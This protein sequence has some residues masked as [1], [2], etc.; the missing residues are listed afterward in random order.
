M[1]S[2]IKIFKT[3]EKNN[4]SLQ[5]KVEA[6]SGMKRCTSTPTDRMPI[7]LANRYVDFDACQHILSFVDKKTLLACRLVSRQF[8]NLVHLPFQTKS[9]SLMN[10]YIVGLYLKEIFSDKVSFSE[11]EAADIVLNIKKDLFDE[12]VD[13]IN[14]KNEQAQIKKAELCKFKKLNLSEIELCYDNFEKLN[15][16][17]DFFSSHVWKLK[18]GT[19]G[20]NLRTSSWSNLIELSVIRIPCSQVLELNNLKIKKLNITEIYD[21][22]VDWGNSVNHLEEIILGS[23]K[24]RSINSRN[25]SLQ[26]V[27]NKLKTLRID[28]SDIFVRLHDLPALENLTIGHCHALWLKN[29]PLKEVSTKWVNFLKLENLKNLIKIRIQNRECDC[30]V[31]LKGY[32]GHDITTFIAKERI[33]LE[34]D[35]VEQLHSFELPKQPN[36][37]TL[38]INKKETVP[39]TDKNLQIFLELN[40]K[41]LPMTRKDFPMV[42]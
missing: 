7:C 16:V 36:H 13:L 5:T 33:D 35:A 12:L 2:E 17:L 15:K 22:N 23:I 39:L 28:Q 37:D 34:I 3:N 40:K 14:N 31:L 18:V 9:F 19:L 27:F 30:E 38:K 32:E 1:L 10:K 24:L 21:N 26:T 20:V 11:I 25:Y 6:S 8:F 4:R 42:C 29:L 41:K